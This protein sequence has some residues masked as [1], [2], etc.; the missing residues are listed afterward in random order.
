MY[1]L[2]TPWADK[3]EAPGQI[4]ATVKQSG[5]A[6][7][8]TTSTPHGLVPNNTNTVDPLGRVTVVDAIT[9]PNLNGPT[10]SVMPP[11]QPSPYV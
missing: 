4:L 8:F 3:M 6:V 1:C 10:M 7:T 9:N 5:N 11:P 2:R